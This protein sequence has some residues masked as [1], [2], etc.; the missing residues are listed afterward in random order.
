MFS[1]RVCINF[2]FLLLKH[3]TLCELIQ[4]N[5]K[6]RIIVDS[7]MAYMYITRTYFLKSCI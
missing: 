7:K 4:I 6:D 2:I 3:F 5:K 1:V